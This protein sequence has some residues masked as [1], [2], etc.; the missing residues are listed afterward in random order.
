MQLGV[1][2]PY[3]LFRTTYWSNLQG[4]IN[5]MRENIA[6]LKFTDGL[7]FWEFVDCLIF[8]NKHNIS[9]ASVFPFN[10]AKKH[11]IWLIF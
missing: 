10:Q 8:F 1:V 4:S 9:E 5:P 7:L 3:R 11:L 6:Q 2:I